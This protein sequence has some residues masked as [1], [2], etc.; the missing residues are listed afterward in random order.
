MT[1]LCCGGIT[2]YVG[3]TLGGLRELKLIL[4]LIS[5]LVLMK[6]ITQRESFVNYI[7]SCLIF[8]IPRFMLI[9]KYCVISPLKVKVIL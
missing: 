5:I 9:S 3:N 1:C 2:L 6:A 4:L 8:Q 7:K